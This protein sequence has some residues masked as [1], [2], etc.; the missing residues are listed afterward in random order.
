MS[1][2]RMSLAIVG[3][4]L[5]VA[6]SVLA[7]RHARVRSLELALMEAP[8]APAPDGMVLVPAGDF[9]MGSDAPVAD[10]DEGPL[11]RAF[12]PAYYIDAHEVTNAEYKAYDPSHTYPDGADALPVTGVSLED[13]RAYAVA[14]GKRLPSR[15]EWEKAARGTDGRAYAWGDTFDPGKAN[16]GG[17]KALAP[18]GSFPEGV[19]PYGAHDMIGNAWEW[20]EDTHVDRP[21]FDRPS[22]VREII[23]GG[24]YSYN[25]YQ[26]RASYNGFEPEGGTCH[27]T[28]F[29]CAKDAV[30]AD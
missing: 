21:I 26:S 10:P 8:V 9:L 1:T 11:R 6:L 2:R 25:A 30:P 22:P 5:L 3:L 29:R 12:L 7:A 13:A 19:S 28:G 20:V 14:Q 17:A 4:T 15:A 27:D 23:K 18:V 16:V 24:G